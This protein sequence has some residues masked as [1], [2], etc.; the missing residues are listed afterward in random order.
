MVFEEKNYEKIA[1]LCYLSPMNIGKNSD[2]KD[3]EGLKE[4][5]FFLVKEFDQKERN[6]K[7]EIIILNE[8]IKNLQDRLFGRKT[9]KIHKPDGQLSLFDM[10]E[11]DL[12]IQKERKTAY[13]PKEKHFKEI[14]G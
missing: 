9:Q 11:S 5:L 2:I 8:P 6:Y 12:P 1:W 7:S 14:C 13:F 10:A 3:I 4:N